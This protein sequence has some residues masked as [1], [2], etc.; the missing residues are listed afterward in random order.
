MDSLNKNMYSYQVPTYI[1]NSSQLFV[2]VYTCVLHGLR[3][4]FT[5]NVLSAKSILASTHTATWD[6]K[7]KADELSAYQPQY[8]E[9][10]WQSMR[11]PFH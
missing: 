2:L 10:E 6:N 9:Y 4:L 1:D 5:V 11:L 8:T 3:V 7:N